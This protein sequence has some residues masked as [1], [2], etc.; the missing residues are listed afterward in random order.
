[1]RR[2]REAIGKLMGTLKGRLQAAMRQGGPNAAVR[3]C[4]EEAQRLTERVASESGVRVGRASLRL[5]NPKN[6]PPAWVARWLQAQGER[7]AEGV[8][9]FERIEW[10]EARVLRPLTVQPLCTTC[11]GMPEQIDPG[12]RDVLAERYPEDRATG[13]RPG[14]LRGALW[15]AV[16]VAPTEAVRP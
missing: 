10:G 15:A 3:V 12:V 11:H 13:Y 1:M 4:A 8:E 5:R 6:E 14:D 16:E 2:A 7:S 9:G